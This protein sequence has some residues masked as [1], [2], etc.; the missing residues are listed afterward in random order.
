M[1]SYE[2]H[3]SRFDSWGDNNAP[4]DGGGGGVQQD[5]RGGHWVNDNRADDFPNK[6]R[7]F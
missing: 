3:N 2:R 4:A 1:S 6:R 5:N 7:R